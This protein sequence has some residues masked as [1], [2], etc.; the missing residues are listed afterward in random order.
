MADTPESPRSASPTDHATVPSELAQQGVG[1]GKVAITLDVDESGSDSEDSDEGD[2]E[3]V[4]EDE[5]RNTPRVLGGVGEEPV[6][7]QQSSSDSD[8]SDD[9]KDE[10]DESS[11][12][13]DD[14]S[15]EDEDDHDHGDDSASDIAVEEPE[16]RQAIEQSIAR[17]EGDGAQESEGD[18]DMGG[19]MVESEEEED[20]S[21]EEEP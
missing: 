8:E 2:D 7:T 16:M 21:D 15:S 3:S 4:V 13:E 12:D 9:E 19:D 20:D 10:D 18:V 6:E 11:E 17:R 14:E 1:A 5:R